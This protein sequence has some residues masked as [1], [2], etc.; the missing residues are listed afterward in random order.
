MDAKPTRSVG[1]I[2]LCLLALGACQKEPIK[3]VEV[4]DDGNSQ[5]AGKTCYGKALPNQYILSWSDGSHSIFYG[6]KD[7]LELELN[8]SPLTRQIT[9]AEQDR[10]LQFESYLMADESVNPKSIFWQVWGQED[11][12]ANVLW[13]ENIKGAG[14]TV[15]VVDAGVDR[16][17]PSLIHRIA[18]NESEIPDNGQDDDK[19]GLVDDYQGFDFAYKE[20]YAKASNHGTH[21]AGI[22]A[23]EPKGN[24]ML[25]IAPGAQILP[26]NIMGD[27]GGGSLAAAVFAIKY[28]QSRGAKVINASWGGAVCAETLKTMIASVA[29]QGILFVAAAGN[30]GVDIE[31]FPEFPAAFDLGNQITVGATMQSGLMAAFSNYGR[32]R[33]HVLAPGHQI[34]SSVPGGW[35][36][37]SGTSMAAPFVSGM[38][39]L[40]WSAHPEASLTQVKRAILNSVKTPQAYHP[41]LAQGRINIPQGLQTL[42]ALLQQSEENSVKQTK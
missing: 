15:A 35:Y 29:E 9:M 14:V 34:Y 33:V 31:V 24:P 22:I 30:D 41:V 4:V 27:T 10:E 3:P 19:N 25:G 6:T 38:A 5:F 13:E 28:A 36:A 40:L 11:V 32:N 37:A 12:Q 20:P 18:T 2:F 7:Q 17:H 8:K 21:V 39:A 26:L 23:A 1:F 16:S 42:R